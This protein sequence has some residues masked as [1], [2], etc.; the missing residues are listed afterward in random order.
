MHEFLVARLGTMV[1]ATSLLAAC[2]RDRLAVPVQPPTDGGLAALLGPVT[3][4]VDQVG[5]LACISANAAG[6]R[7]ALVWPNGFAATPTTPLAI[8]DSGGEPVAKA[9]DTV[10]L[11]GGLAPGPWLQLGSCPDHDGRVWWVADVS[12]SAP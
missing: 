10:W 2:A 8:I 6:Q 1:F 3:L 9:G 5:D 4:V 7:T 12:H 11:G